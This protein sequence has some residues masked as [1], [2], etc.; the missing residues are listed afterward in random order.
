MPRHVICLRSVIYIPSSKNGDICFLDLCGYLSGKQIKFVENLSLSKLSSLGV[1]G[2]CRYAAYPKNAEQLFDIYSLCRDNGINVRVIGKATNTWFADGE[3]STVLIIT[4]RMRSIT[5]DMDG[6]VSLQAGAGLTYSINWLAN[7]GIELFPSLS[8]IPGTVGG[9]VYNNAGAFGASVADNLLYAN[10]LD[11]DSGEVA[12]LNASDLKLSYRS[13]A[14]HGRKYVLLDC[15]FAT[16]RSDN[17]DI[18]E[19]IKSAVTARQR[20]H[21]KEASLGSFFKRNADVIPAYLIDKLGLKGY[22]IGA[23]AISNRHAGF[24][25]NKGGASAADV[26]AL[27]SFVESSVYRA[28]GVRL[29]REAEYIG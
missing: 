10:V 20:L 4:D 5:F 1:G 8:G 17:A 16:S 3:I 22:S 28:F 19:K 12:R 11:V 13:S 15:T 26:E 25:I 7:R 14:L 9:A 18:K 6:T 24:I 29:L 21:P 23:A 2:Y 27:A